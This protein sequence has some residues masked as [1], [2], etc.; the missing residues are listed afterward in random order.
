MVHTIDA[1][2]V[3]LDTLRR[4][5]QDEY[6]RVVD[7]PELG[8]HFLVGR[9]LARVLEYDDAWLQGIPEPT[10]AWF[11]GTGNPFSAQLYTAAGLS[12]VH[13][14]TGPF[15]MMTPGGFLHDEGVPNAVEVMARA[16]SRLC[17]VRK[18]AWLAPRVAR[19]V[20][21]LGFILVDGVKPLPATG[22]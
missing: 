19:A 20:L 13:V 2:R 7:E 21:Y 11:A 10:I 5:I 14:A 4:A 6:A 16:L 12:G 17:Y 3:D 18:M 9:P 8:F 22:G 15:D 1:P